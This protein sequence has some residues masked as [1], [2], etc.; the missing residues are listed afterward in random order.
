M[1]MSSSTVPH[2]LPKSG[3]NSCCNGTWIRR[4]PSAQ[5]GCS[6]DTDTY[7]T[8]VLKLVPHPVPG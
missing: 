5:A 3:A 7:H 1:G 6:R 4:R 2:T 8:N